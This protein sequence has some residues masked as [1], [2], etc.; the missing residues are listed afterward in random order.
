MHGLL[1]ILRIF[2]ATAWTCIVGLPVVV[3]IYATYWVGQLC[4]LFGREDIL[5]RIIAWNAYVTGGVAQ[6]WWAPF[7]LKL[8][9]VTAWQRAAQSLDWSRSY[10][11]C[12]N[13]ASVFDILVLTS[14]LP[15][16]IRFVAKRELLKWPV[17]GWS[18]RP[19]GQIVVDRQHTADAVRSIDTATRRRIGGQVIFFVEGTRTRDGELLPFKRGAFHFAIANQMPVLPTAVVG[20]FAAL[21]RMPWWK[22]HPGR[23]IGVVFGSPIEPPQL[24][25]GE[26]AAPKVD[27]LSAATRAQIVA[28]LAQ[29]PTRAE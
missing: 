5:N 16:P 9:G 12:S 3:V 23:D 17:I 20:S 11:I 26:A 27:E 6:R 14:I 28:L 13:H 8:C 2:V 15:L 18:L 7:L 21:A 29:A 25:P 4:A 22:L 10:V 1:N 24:R 19:A